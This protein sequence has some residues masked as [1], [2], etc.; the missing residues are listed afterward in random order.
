MGKFKSWNE[1]KDVREKFDNKLAEQYCY[2]TFLVKLEDASK[3]LSQVR[4]DKNFYL[5][6]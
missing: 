6:Y 2:I 4:I 3:N 5:S 1:K